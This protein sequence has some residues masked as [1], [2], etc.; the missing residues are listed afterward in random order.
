M[1]VS[2]TNELHT[3]ILPCLPDQQQAA[4][5]SGAGHGH[6]QHY[7]VEEGFSVACWDMNPQQSAFFKMP[8]CAAQNVYSFF[9]D[10]SSL[11]GTHYARKA[12]V[13]I[14]PK[15]V[16]NAYF[17]TPGTAT[18]YTS[19]PHSH[20]KGLQF[21]VSAGFL[22]KMLL[23]TTDA[24]TAEAILLQPTYLSL[25]SDL[26]HKLECLNI[27]PGKKHN[28]ISIFSLKGGFY[29]ILAQLIADLIQSKSKKKEDP[30]A[31]ELI[32]LNRAL[33]QDVCPDIPSIATAARQLHIST[34]KL[35]QLQKKV[36]LVPFAKY[37]QEQRL[38]KAKELLQDSRKQIKEIAFDLGYNSGNHFARSFRQKFGVAPS[39]YQKMS[40]ATS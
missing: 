11:P 1:S 29:M 24:A 23:Q 27:T 38:A 20:V 13:E 22:K 15:A 37:H 18:A 19:S 32:S 8:D 3:V 4:N 10:N 21:L 33:Q 39:G 14:G 25:Q 35:K 9:I 26:F 31:E 28:P 34:T 17:N 40:S 16:A 12:A 6:L 30:E 5:E 2:H 36:Y 7:F